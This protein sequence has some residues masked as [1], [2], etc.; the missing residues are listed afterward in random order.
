[1]ASDK[2]KTG[3]GGVTAADIARFGVFRSRVGGGRG[4]KD[5]IALAS[6][7]RLVDEERRTLRRKVI[8]WMVALAVLAYLSLGVMGAAG[9]GIDSDAYQVFTPWEVGY[10]LWMHVYNLF[11]SLSHLYNPHPMSWL[12]ENVPGY[13]AIPE[14]AGVVGITLVCAVLLGVSGML[15]QNVFRNPIA[16]PGMLGVSSGVSLGL[17]A[18]VWIYGASASGMLAERYMLC[19]GC[20]AAIL[21]FVV[22][23]GRKLSGKGKPFDIVTMLLLGSILSQLLG[24]VVSY[25][26]LYVMD[27]DYYQIYYTLSAMLVVD[28]SPVSWACLGVA[29]AISFIPVWLLRFRM[30]AL[31]F[32]EQ[33]VKLFGINFTLLRAVALVC[34]AIMI[35]AAQVHTGSVALISLIV[36]FLSRSWFGCEFRKQLAG[37]VCIGTVLLLICR[38]I[39]DLIPF[40]GDG[41]AIGSA[42]SVVALPLFIVIMAKQMRGWE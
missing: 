32:E 29:F 41:I 6:T 40:V 7:E 17:M 22:A 8:G 10:A 42:V 15:Y 14:R 33:E 18:L 2:Q 9:G 37:N 38:D 36:P 20:G 31:A 39:V 24:F 28:A 27:P 3:T 35:L 21:I 11:G 12:L 30:N 5:G 25:V 26:T 1:M 16:G 13:Y 34:G 19:Y 4:G 23:A